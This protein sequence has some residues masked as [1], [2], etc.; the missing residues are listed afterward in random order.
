MMGALL[1]G[2]RREASPPSAGGRLIYAIG[3]THGRFDLL[4]DLLSEIV[5]DARNSNP[6]QR[7]MLIFL[8]DYIDRGPESRFVVECLCQLLTRR[9][10]EVRALM[11]NHEEALLGFLEDPATAAGWLD[12][13]GLA[14]LTSYGV[15][16][17]AS[18]VDPAAF[19]TCRNQ[20]AAAIPP[21]HLKFLREL[22]LSVVVG[23]YLFVHA[24]VRPGVPLADQNPRDLLWIR[25]EFLRSRRPCDKVVVHGHSADEEAHVLPHRLGIDTGA[26]ATGLL[27]AARIDD[28]GVRLIQVR[29]T[30]PVAAFGR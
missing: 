19:E 13:G 9:D 3:D 2:F 25:Q 10:V 5:A 30:D 18:R 1:T 29:A 8:G 15:A 22:E 26:Y 12:F 16:P 14:T 11:G 27:T 6:A 23:D 28:G 4:Q 21:R 17:P 20:L 24:G 7:P